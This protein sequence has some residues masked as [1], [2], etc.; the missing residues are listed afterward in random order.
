VFFDPHLQKQPYSQSSMNF[1]NFIS[2][3]GVTLSSLREL[4]YFSQYCAY[5]L[6]TATLG[7]DDP[8]RAAMPKPE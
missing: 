4:L 1:L 5:I 3:E 2:S 6:L 7:P 8:N